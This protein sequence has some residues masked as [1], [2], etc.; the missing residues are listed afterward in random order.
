M[1]AKGQEKKSGGPSRGGDCPY[2]GRVRDGVCN[3]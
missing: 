2:K 1:V 3:I